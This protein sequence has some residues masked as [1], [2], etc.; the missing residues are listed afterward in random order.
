MIVT[1]IGPRPLALKGNSR[2]AAALSRRS[3]NHRELLELSPK[4]GQSDLSP[5]LYPGC[6][7]TNPH[8]TRKY[9]LPY[10]KGPKHW[11]TFSLPDEGQSRRLLDLQRDDFFR[12]SCKRVV[13]TTCRI[14]VILYKGESPRASRG[15][16]AVRRGAA[17][18]EGGRSSWL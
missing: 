14:G 3:M 4:S 13:L 16:S 7:N 18:T 11:A 6:L 12:P 1:F 9:C 15:T 5:L 10:H 8:T 2:G 17:L